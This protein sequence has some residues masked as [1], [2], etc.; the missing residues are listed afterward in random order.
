MQFAFGVGHG[1]QIPVGFVGDIYSRFEKSFSLQPGETISI[2]AIINPE[3]L[4]GLGITKVGPLEATLSATGGPVQLQNPLVW[5]EGS[6][7]AC[8]VPQKLTELVLK[9][10]GENTVSGTVAIVHK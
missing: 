8:P 5:V 7:L 4:V 2:E 9:N 1:A 3:R 10:I 6:G